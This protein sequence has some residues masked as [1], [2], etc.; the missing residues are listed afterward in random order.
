[1]NQNPLVSVVIT[2]HNRGSVLMRRALA[3]VLAQTHKNIEC[4]IINDGSTDNT[5]T[6][7]REKEK[8]DP[9]I[10]YI[11]KE[12]GGPSAARNLGIQAASG[13]FI[14]FTDDDDEFLP[15]YLEEAMR[16]FRDLSSEIGYVSCGVKN[17]DEEGLESYYLPELEP[18]WKLS[19]GNGWVFRSEIF[20]EHHITF[21][22]RL[23][24]YEDLDLHLRV[25]ELGYRGYII[26]QPLRIYYISLGGS[27]TE[28]WSSNYSQQI[29][30]LEWFMK[31]HGSLYDGQGREA[32]G[33]ID[34]MGGL[35]H[36]RGGDFKKGKKL[37][38]L[39]CKEKFSPLAGIYLFASL[40]GKKTVL[41]FD[42]RK[43][44]IMRYVRARILNRLP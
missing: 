18:F 10:R 31:K 32:R 39:S 38:L 13:E 12:N 23:R 30:S 42:D 25:H 27:T 21:D 9:R 16:I 1:M 43:G 14:A 8:T 28:S 11:K 15:E 2:T 20:K 5:E 40:F 26:E 24:G 4:I 7:V 44:H 41:A 22:E 19:I 3:S 29:V 6:L 33:W 35:T 34:V 37:L 36:L 17:R